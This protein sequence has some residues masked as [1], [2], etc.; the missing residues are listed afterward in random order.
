MIAN[1][2]V[3]SIQLLPDTD[4]YSESKELYGFTYKMPIGSH[5]EIGYDINNDEIHVYKNSWV[6]TVCVCES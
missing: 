2:L 1:Y 3:P 5:Q 6:R 4:H